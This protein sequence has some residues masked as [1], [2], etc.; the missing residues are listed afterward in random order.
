M[1]CPTSG[2][3]KPAIVK[4][5]YGLYAA[6]EDSRLHVDYVCKECGQELWDRASP[7]VQALLMHFVLES[8]NAARW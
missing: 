4:I 8:I 1:L 5:T 2:C 7:L 3:G 6:Y